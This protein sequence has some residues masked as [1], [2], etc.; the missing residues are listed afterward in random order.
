[1]YDFVDKPIMSLGKGGQFLV[2]SMRAWVSALGQHKCPV[3]AIAP[4]FA[5]R[6]M[7]GALQPFHL[8]MVIL[9]R[10][11]QQNFGFAPIPCGFVS[12]HE[13]ILLSFFRA[14]R[15]SRPDVVRATAEMLVAEDAV[16]PF[17]LTTTRVA[18]ALAAHDL[19][20]ENPN[21]G[22]SANRLKQ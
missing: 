3:P 1:M 19:M 16:H 4:A 17:I 10:D 11:G 7:I 2:W 20:P 5:K 18:T 12:E 15:D 9:N 8:A 14:F 21:V 13:A 6:N 22:F